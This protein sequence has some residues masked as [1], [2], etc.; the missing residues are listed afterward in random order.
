MGKTVWILGSGFSKPLNGPLLRDLF[1][2]EQVE[3]VEAEFPGE[4]YPGLAH[5]LPWVQRYF[6]VGLKQGL[7][8]NAEQFLARVDDA[9]RA[10]VGPKYDRLR[11]LVGTTLMVDRQGALTGSVGQSEAEERFRSLATS[12]RRGLAAECVRFLMGTDP[13]SE[14]W[15]PYREWVKSLQ[16]HTDT[17]VCFNYDR[18]IEMAAD[19]AAVKAKIWVAL[20]TE[21]QPTGS[22]PVLKLHGSVDWRLLGQ[23]RE[24]RE[25]LD[26]KRVDADYIL[27][28][29]DD[30][31]G[32]AAPGGT[33]ARFVAMHMEPLWARA[34]AA[35]SEADRVI[36]VGYSF[37][38]TDP[39]AQER[40]LPAFAKGEAHER[41]AHLV[42][43]AGVSDV[44][45][46][47]VSLMRSTA[48]PNHWV[49]VTDQ[50]AP[51]ANHPHLGIVQHPLWAQ[52]FL[53]RH[54][55]FTP[56]R[57]RAAT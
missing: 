23:S 52:D 32:I 16:P 19:A 13:Q 55:S 51:G 46:R 9:C 43:G 12:V 47:L 49:R 22:V 14:A 28:T 1:K 11:V 50:C 54:Q 20:P 39:Y 53:L 37:P 21:Q 29:P 10:G 4:K 15:L 27:R 57:A 33:K 35:L 41:H 26:D 44:S 36:I 7:W 30:V 2:Q 17:V 48:G 40:L 38:D 8:D 18:V 42:L 3:D 6:H 34:V 45:R 56:P 5:S 24:P 31:I 25:Y